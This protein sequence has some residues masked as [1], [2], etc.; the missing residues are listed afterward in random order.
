MKFRKKPVIIEAFRWTG[1]PDQTGDPEWI[2][3]ALREEKVKIKKNVFNE[4]MM[5]IST[6][7]GRMIAI[8]GD[9]IIQGV[10]G[11]LYPC[12]SDVFEETYEPVLFSH[13]E[14]ENEMLSSQ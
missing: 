10:K 6:F 1:G 9:W 2:I 13:E 12:K 14:E 5:V 8:P 7:E 4:I 11:E 3:Q